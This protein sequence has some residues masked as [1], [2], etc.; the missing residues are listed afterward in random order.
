[1]LVSVFVVYSTSD[2]IGSPSR[3]W[4]LLSE[5]AILH[6]VQGNAQGSYLTMDSQSKDQHSMCF[7]DLTDKI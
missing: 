5:A 3:M 4:D 2:L 6:P 7:L 1:M